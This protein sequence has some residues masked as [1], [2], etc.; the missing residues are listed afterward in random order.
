MKRAFEM[1]AA[2]GLVAL[3]GA[4]AV[5][6]GRRS[7]VRQD[8][9]DDELFP[10]I[11]SRVEVGDLLMHVRV[12]GQE[13]R[14]LPTVVFENGMSSPLELWGW[15]QPEVAEVTRTVAYDRAGLGWTPSHKSSPTAE[16]VS[17]DLERLLEVLDCPGPYILVGHSFGGLLIRHFA[18]RRPDQVA[19][20]VLVDSA[21]PDQFDRSSRQRLGLSPTL[22]I[23]RQRAMLM[24]FGLARKK[25]AE[26][27][28]SLT[29]GL[30]GELVAPAKARL[31]SARTWRG[32]AAEMTAWVE[33]INPEIRKVVTPAHC[34]LAVVT[35]GASVEADPIHGVLQEE[36]AG[37]VTGS[38]HEILANAEHMGLLT[39]RENGHLV[40]KVIEEMVLS[41]GGKQPSQQ[42]A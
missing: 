39:D 16:Q 30:P 8:H 40:A 24:S 38:K 18:H 27:T 5:I 14:G 34:R 7:A 20:L 32:T 19:G 3:A 42:G 10:G 36:L 33:H 23:T 25:S 6:G 29:K 28:S 12:L 31:R 22:S 37:L 9:R 15:I 1:P 2:I 26:E 4:A 35:A 21:H 11:G 41:F 17:T 13:H